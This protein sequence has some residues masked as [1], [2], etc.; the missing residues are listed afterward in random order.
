MAEISIRRVA[1]HFG[2]FTALHSVDLTI[3]EISSR[4]R[5]VLGTQVKIRSNDQGSGTIGIEFYS[6]EDLERL[7]D[8]FAVIERNSR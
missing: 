4:L 3:A 1:K 2:N 8:L 5:Q 7:L 6:L